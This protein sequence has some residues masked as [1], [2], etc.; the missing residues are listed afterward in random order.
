MTRQMMEN[1]NIL[2]VFYYQ[3]VVPNESDFFG[4]F[5]VSRFLEV[6][7][8]GSSSRDKFAVFVSI[9]LVPA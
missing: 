5:Q 1:V 3:T 9:D 4:A 6:N 2:T 7:D 8:L